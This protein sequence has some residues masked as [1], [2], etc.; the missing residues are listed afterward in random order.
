MQTLSEKLEVQS[1]AYRARNFDWALKERAEEL[2]DKAYPGDVDLT[3]LEASH[4]VYFGYLNAAAVERGYKALP[5]DPHDTARRKA[6]WYSI[7]KL[8]L[9]L[10][11]MEL[12]RFGI[13]E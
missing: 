12:R 7:P 3:P 8:D 6:R 10:A 1:M 5:A 2:I 13:I 11:A 9:E 4:E